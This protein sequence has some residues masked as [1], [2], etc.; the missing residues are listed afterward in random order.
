LL[1]EAQAGILRHEYLYPGMDLVPVSS[2][3]KNCSLRC[4]FIVQM[5]IQEKQHELDEVA[6]DSFLFTMGD[7]ILEIIDSQ[8]FLRLLFP[9][10][11]GSSSE[12]RIRLVARRLNVCDPLL[13]G[14]IPLLLRKFLMDGDEQSC[15]RRHRC[16][17]NDND[18]WVPARAP[19]LVG[20]KEIIQPSLAKQLLD[21][22][23]T[24]A[25]IVRAESGN[26]KFGSGEALHLSCVARSVLMLEG[27]T[28]LN[29][30]AVGFD[31]LSLLAQ[32]PIPFP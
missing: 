10:G 2:T 26:R 4:V 18:W 31:L 29:N 27:K 5:R 30:T 32:C 6:C 16:L 8:N 3:R 15:E 23:G 9:A 21:R 22:E 28:E 1:L 13:K 20:P 12:P 24:D 14:G 11:I 17:R 7:R 25:L 19:G